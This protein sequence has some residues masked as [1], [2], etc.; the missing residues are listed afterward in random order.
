MNFLAQA[1]L[2]LDKATPDRDKQFFRVGTESEISQV[3]VVLQLL[4]AF[5]RRGV[6]DSQRRRVP[7]CRTMLREITFNSRSRRDPLPVGTD[8]DRCF[9]GKLM[10]EFPRSRIPKCARENQ[11]WRP[12]RSFPRA[13]D[14]VPDEQSL[15]T[16]DKDH[17]NLACQRHRQ[18]RAQ[19][20][21]LNIEKEHAMG[22][23]WIE[24]I[25]EV[26][27]GQ[28]RSVVIQRDRIIGGPI[29]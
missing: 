25:A 14:C 21:G 11:L 10:D 7:N 9:V 4:N 27:Q 29:D 22:L 2:P 19:T 3:A 26:G 13:P 18:C 16:S 1:P 20:S 28:L 12:S 17:A 15:P 5:A 8:A 23:S 24:G 6:P